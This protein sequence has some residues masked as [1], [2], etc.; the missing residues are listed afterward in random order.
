M[1]D[2]FFGVGPMKKQYLSALKLDLIQVAL[3]HSPT[4]LPTI[5]S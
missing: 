3:A 1:V 4:A 2:G 5:S